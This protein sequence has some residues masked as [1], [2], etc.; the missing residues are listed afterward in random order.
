[1]RRQA[2]LRWPDTLSCLHSVVSRVSEHAVTDPEPLFLFK[3]KKKKRWDF[4]ALNSSQVGARCLTSDR[5][6][7]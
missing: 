4:P 1:M 7:V 6:E 2:C 5:V 3:K